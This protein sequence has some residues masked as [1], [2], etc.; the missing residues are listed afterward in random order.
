M[1]PRS[2]PGQGLID[3]DSSTLRLMVQRTPFSPRSTT[4]I[5]LGIHH[6]FVII[7]VNLPPPGPHQRE[8]T[9]G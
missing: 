6:L 8:K 9:G 5:G 3:S 2:A 4:G 7:K 1:P